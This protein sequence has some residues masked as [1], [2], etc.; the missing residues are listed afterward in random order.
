MSNDSYKLRIDRPIKVHYEGPEI[1]GGKSSIN[2]L[3]TNDFDE[4]TCEKC[5]DTI[6]RRGLRDRPDLED[7]SVESSNVQ[8]YVDKR[9]DTLKHRLDAASNAMLERNAQRRR[10][11]QET[12]DSIISGRESLN[13][14]EVLAL[15]KLGKRIIK[16]LSCD[17]N[18]EGIPC[19][20][21]RFTAMG[22]MLRYLDICMEAKE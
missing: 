7:I 12:V 4:V 8:A 9:D 20:T 15:A 17:A 11:G 18:G 3:R 21:D 1:H 14:E 10:L 5:L 19:R 6:E 13:H 2:T 22:D 16:A